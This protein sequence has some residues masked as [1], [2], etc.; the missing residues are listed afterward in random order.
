MLRTIHDAQP[1]GLL[2]AA[3][4]HPASELWCSHDSEEPFDTRHRTGSM[5]ASFDTEIDLATNDDGGFFWQ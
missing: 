4:R 5:L 2:A 1:L 3:F